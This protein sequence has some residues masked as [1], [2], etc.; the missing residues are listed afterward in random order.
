MERDAFLDWV[1]QLP[2][3]LN[4]PAVVR[5]NTDKVYLR[6]LEAGG[7]PNTPTTYVSPGET[8]TP[9]TGGE[10]VVKPTISAGSQD[11]ANSAIKAKRQRADF[12]A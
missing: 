9:P 11:T 12:S 5:W 2:R 3:V 1:G 6:D 10:W 4:G 8:W 7:V